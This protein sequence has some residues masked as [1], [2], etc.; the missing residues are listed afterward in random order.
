[1]DRMA[2]RTRQPEVLRELFGALGNNP[3]VIAECLVRP[4]L[5]KSLV[6]TL[7]EHDQ[8]L[9]GEL[10]PPAESW[11]KTAETQTPN[12]M[13]AAPA[14]YSLSTISG[15]AGCTDDSWTATS[16]TKAPA[17]R[18]SQTAVWTG[19]E[20]IVWGGYGGSYFNTGGRYNPSTDS[21]SAISTINAPTARGGHTAVWTGNEMIVWGG[22][23][24]HSLNTGGR[25][26]PA[27]D[28][29]TATSTAIAPTGGYY[30]TAVWTGNEMIAWG[31]YD[32]SY[33]NTGGRYC[34]QSASPTPTPTPT[35]TGTPRPAPTSRPRP[36]RAPRP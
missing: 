35:P 29:W 21:W 26:N 28:T 6:R 23:D 3:F 8:R 22:D 30:H 4:V 31:G 36:T 11:R 32:G 19:S 7:Y 27:N 25:Y 2:K 15:G 20:M 5:S 1:M 13:A 17:G 34:A 10:E 18:N 24:G 16:I 12:V 33:L 9:H 14:N